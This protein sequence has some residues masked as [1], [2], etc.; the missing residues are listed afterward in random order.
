MA[1]A[2][3]INALSP[4][5]YWRLG[6][7]SGTVMTDSSGNSYD[8]TYVG[9]PTLGVASL[10]A[11]DADTCVTFNASDY[12]YVEYAFGTVKSLAFIV[13]PVT[14]TGQDTIF[15]LMDGTTTVR[16]YI[17]SADNNYLKITDDTTTVA[18]T[19]SLNTGVTYHVVI[20]NDI[21]DIDIYVNGSS[22][23]DSTE[24]IFSGL[25]VTKVGIHTYET[26]T[27][28]ESVVNSLSPVAYWRLG[29]TSGVTAYDELSGDDLNLFGTVTL[30]Q[31]SLVPSD[32]SNKAMAFD[33]V[34]GFFEGTDRDVYSIN[35][36]G[37]LA[38]SFLIKADTLAGW[39]G[40][41]GKGTAS[42]YEWGIAIK[43]G[44]LKAVFDDPVGYVIRGEKATI[45][46]G[47]THHIVLN[48]TGTTTTSE[49]EI[50]V[51]GV[52]SNSFDFADG[53]AGPYGN[54]NDKITIGRIYAGFAYRYFDGVL[55]E[56]VIFDTAL[57]AANV[58]DLY[59]ATGL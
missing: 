10:Q 17:D 36:T 6:E 25:T 15:S 45:S 44:V 38:I 13:K 41:I 4:L 49:I 56:V 9:S 28:Y 32:A 29:E 57:S 22:V 46:A 30:N 16:V 24:T 50:Y 40:I 51:D 19:I 58:A 48:Y 47:T 8:G 37:Q 14:L 3:D 31:N 18:T 26:V 33:G 27:T 7:S 59:N 12:G 53:P 39:Q 21:G 42:N 55:D 1:Y 2:D 52:K 20:T 34:D 11:S 35:T 23:L 5:A 43:D 54:T